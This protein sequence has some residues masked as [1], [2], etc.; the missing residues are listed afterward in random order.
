MA[1]AGLMVN[2]T[3][4]AQELRTGAAPG[5]EFSQEYT[6]AVV[7]DTAERFS[8]ILEACVGF[9]ASM[10]SGPRRTACSWTNRGRSWRVRVREHS[11]P[12]DSAW[13]YP[14]PR[15]RK[16]RNARSEQRRKPRRLWRL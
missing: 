12:Q 2:V 11:I 4:P 1:R 15:S 10:A 9:W 7:R 3:V 5:G 14:W 16:R 6:A 8:R 13:K